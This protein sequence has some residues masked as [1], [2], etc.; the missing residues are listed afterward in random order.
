ML[1]EG[2]YAKKIDV[3]WPEDQTFISKRSNVDLHG[4][5]CQF[6]VDINSQGK[7]AFTGRL[8][9]HKSNIRATGTPSLKLVLFEKL[10]LKMTKYPP[11][12][13]VNQA[14]PVLQAFRHLGN[15]L[16][17]H[18]VKEKLQVSV[19]FTFPCTSMY[20]KFLRNEYTLGF[21]QESTGISPL[22]KIC[23]SSVMYTSEF[24]YSGYI[25]V[26]L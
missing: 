10:H 5:F 25:L 3:E 2:K 23:S 18:N 17:A 19:T 6:D 26:L 14:P 4:L 22:R 13:S 9:G 11:Q 24:I 7:D 20:Q 21:S 8:A 12:S 15:C 1:I 16:E